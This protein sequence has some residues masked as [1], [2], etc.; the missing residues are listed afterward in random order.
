M[1]NSALTTRYNELQAAVRTYEA[2]EAR[3]PGLWD[4][5]LA[6]AKGKLRNFEAA[7]VIN[8]D[9]TVVA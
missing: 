1:T 5:E 2:R 3:R 7:H 9:G 4:E 6:A 8:A